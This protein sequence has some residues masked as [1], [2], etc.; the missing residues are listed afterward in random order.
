VRTEDA[1]GEILTPAR[2]PCAGNPAEKGLFSAISLQMKGLARGPCKS[3]EKKAASACLRVAASWKA[4][5]GGVVR[6]LGLVKAKP[7]PMIKVL[8]FPVLMQLRLRRRM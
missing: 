2:P 4:N 7:V 6:F 8:V 1:R 3:G 5:T